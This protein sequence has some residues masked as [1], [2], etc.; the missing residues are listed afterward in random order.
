M[1]TG[2]PGDDPIR[3]VAE[4]GAHLFTNEIDQLIREV[5]PV[6]TAGAG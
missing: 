5:W 1:A 4:R 3:D 2:E 6:W